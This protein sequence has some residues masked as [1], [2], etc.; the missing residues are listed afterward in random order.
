MEAL[1]RQVEALQ[2]Q[3]E[4]MHTA[5]THNRNYNIKPRLFTGHTSEDAVTFVNKFIDYMDYTRVPEAQ[6]SRT[7]RMYVV[8]VAYYWYKQLPEDVTESPDFDNLKELFLKRFSNDA[9]L[10][11][12]KMRFY[13][14]KQGPH[15]SL[16]AFINQFQTACCKLNLPGDELCIVFVKGLSPTIK[17][18]VLR[19]R[20]QSLED[21]IDFA[22]NEDACIHLDTKISDHT[23]MLHQLIEADDTALHR[24]Q[25]LVSSGAYY[26][27]RLEDQKKYDSIL[28]AL[29]DIRQQIRPSESN[30]FQNRGNA[31]NLR[32]HICNKFGHFAARCWQKNQQNTQT[33]SS[34]YC[35]NH[36]PGGHTT[37]QCRLNMNRSATPNQIPASRPRPQGNA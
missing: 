24:R 2:T 17:S 3:L 35:A 20:P 6:R 27:D 1:V 7:F 30:S 11:I 5:T 8:D 22:R 18:A 12:Q 19:S 25:E 23:P 9:A 13:D 21:A 10:Y 37:S 33:W 32:C 15:Q 16:E 28:Q 31:D 29:D 14:I 34:F 26:K 36:G 4:D